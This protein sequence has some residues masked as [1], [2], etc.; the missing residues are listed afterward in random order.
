MHDVAARQRD[1]FPLPLLKAVA[2]HNDDNR[3]VLYRPS[4]GDVLVRVGMPLT[5]ENMRLVL[6]MFLMII[7][8][9]VPAL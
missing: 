6:S 2:F 8:L 4:V 7:L 1:L 5:T 3:V 9:T